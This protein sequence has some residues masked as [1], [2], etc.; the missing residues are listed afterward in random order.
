MTEES[1]D[2][3]HGFEEMAT[4]LINFAEVVSTYRNALIE[5]GIPLELTDELVL[6]LNR[7]FCSL[8]GKP[9]GE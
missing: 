9:K 7:Q 5:K 2:L 4:T 8:F 1:Y 3:V 6:E